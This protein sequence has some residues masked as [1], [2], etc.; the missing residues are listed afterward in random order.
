MAP[1]KPGRKKAQPPAREAARI[2]AA[3]PPRAQKR[4]V[5][6]VCAALVLA[7][8]AIYGQTLSHE[9]LHY[10]DDLYV[11]E[12]GHVQAGLNLKS[13]GW[14]FVAEDAHYF[15]PLTWMSHMLDCSL[16]GMHPWGHH[17]T[18]LVFHAAASVLLFL[19]LRLLTGALWPSAAVAALFA[20]HPLHVESVA[21]VAERKDV[22]SAFFWML[23][24]G[25]YALYVRRGGMMRYL[26]VMAAFALGLMS[27][28]MV[29]TLPFVL[30]L[31]DY[32]PLDRLDRTAS[33]G[34][35]GQTTARLSVEK[36]PLFLMAIISS[37][38]TLLM[39]AGGTNLAFGD[40]VPFMARCA[41]ATVVYVIYLA[42]TVWPSGLAAFYPHPL[43]RPVWQVAGAA[44]ILA[45]ITLFCLRQTRRHPYLMVGWLWYLGTLVPVIELVQ[46]GQVSHADRYTYL[47][48]IG[49]FVMI[50]WG[51]A[52]LAA[53]WRLPKIA[54]AAV[55]GVALVLLTVCAGVQTGYWQDD[56]T[57]FSHAVAV[58]R[59]S[60]L[61]YN[62][63]GLRAVDQRRYDAARAHFAKA[64]DLDPK[65]V[66]AL[67]NLG[68]LDMDLG[69][70]D[71]AETCLTRALDLKV[72][73]YKVLTN[74]GVLALRQGNYDKARDHLKRALRLNPANVIALTNLGALADYQGR[75]D[76]ARTCL[77]K[78]LDLQPDYPEALGILGQVLMK[79]GDYDKARAC[80]A[81]TLALNPGNL[82][83]LTDIGACCIYQKQ[84]EEAQR[85]CRKALEAD[86][87][88]VSAMRN[89]GIAL[90]KL[91]RQEEAELC[92]KK[93]A[94]LD[95]ARTV[96]KQ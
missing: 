64:L 60:S 21:W 5:A 9:F 39:Q 94:E 36:I 18:S 38:S 25:A 57:L 61:A 11:T 28:P 16:Y 67:T 59:E 70:Y 29:V 77:M 80:L 17:L 30:L 27:K 63:R 72:A 85:Y 7:C 51:A 19:A 8:I 23:A 44:L 74:L 89:L 13:V 26:A 88:S 52:D 24:M 50:A 4:M 34:V 41:N 83:A 96:K 87:Q 53:A 79:Q 46:A 35:L 3:P 92:L 56:E 10:D 84:Y 90:A 86:P 49:L 31:L 58:G 66:H 93:A 47:P 32:W 6:G 45:A 81:R 22:L 20:V 91:G 95:A 43:A 75:D 1:L 78:A 33:L 73:E 42:K 65:D 76:E 69:R 54:V 40:K 62:N 2:P 12:N 55:S 82:R 48:S 14:A 15:H 68:S 71:E 37:V